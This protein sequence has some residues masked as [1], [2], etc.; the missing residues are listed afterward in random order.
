MSSS[1]FEMH[2]QLATLLQYIE[3]MVLSHIEMINAPH[4]WSVTFHQTEDVTLS[5]Q[6]SYSRL[7]SPCDDL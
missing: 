2:F 1:C 4:G 6:F 7:S 5:P 3:I